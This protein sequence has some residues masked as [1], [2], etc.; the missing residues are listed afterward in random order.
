MAELD[1]DK[2]FLKAK[3]HA[4]A[5]ELL[6]PEDWKIIRHKEQIDAGAE[7]TLTEQQYNDLL[8]AR[9]SVRDWS[10]DKEAELDACETREA[11]SQVSLEDY[12]V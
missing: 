9:Q 11:V 1:D 4:K 2:I 12:P 8:T 7:T 6:L 3:V 10:N 5:Y